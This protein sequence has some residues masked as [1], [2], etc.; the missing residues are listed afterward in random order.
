MKDLYKDMSALVAA[1]HTLFT[2]RLAM[3]GE[4]EKAARANTLATKILEYLIRSRPDEMDQEGVQLATHYLKCLVR[5]IDIC[6]T[7]SPYVKLG[8]QSRNNF[9]ASL[10]PSS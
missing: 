10:T 9:Y 1:T 8:K 5:Q 4:I 3:M 7:A 2:H 6:P